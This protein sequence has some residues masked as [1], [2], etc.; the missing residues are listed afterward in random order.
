MKR[1]IEKKNMEQ[2]QYAVMEWP[3]D[4][5]RLSIMHLKNIIQPKK[6]WNEY[7][8]GDKGMC[9][10]PGNGNWEFIIHAVGRKFKFTL[11]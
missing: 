9:A 7:K 11:H 5:N 6:A 2:M 8:K 3:T 10:Y 4:G 1:E